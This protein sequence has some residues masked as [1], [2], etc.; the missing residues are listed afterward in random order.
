[1]GV[2]AEQL[3]VVM[4]A[5]VKNAIAG[6]R[7]YTNE[8]KTLPK[9]TQ[10]VNNSLNQVGKA[11]TK[12]KTD[13]TNFNRVLQDAPFGL[14]AIQNNLTQLVPNIGYLGLAVTA[15][16][17]ALTFAQ[18]GFGA[19]TRGLGSSAEKARD[20]A[21][22]LEEYVDG[23]DDVTRARVAGA[24]NAQE[25]LVSLQTLYKATQNSNIPLADRQY[26]KYFGN[27]KDEII[28][29]GGAEKQ[30]KEL[31][32]AIL[33]TSRA[34]AAQDILVDIQ[35]QLLAVEQKQTD[36]L[37]DQYKQFQLLN[38][39]RKQV[40]ESGEFDPKGIA[41]VNT[42]NVNLQTQLSKQQE[43][44]NSFVG[45]GV[46]LQ[47][48]RNDL[49]RRAENITK[50]ITTIVET[51]PEVL[52]D[53]TGNLPKEIEK[54]I[55]EFPGKYIKDIDI[56]LV[57]EIVI[58]QAALQRNLINTVAGQL[59]AVQGPPIIVDQ[60]EVDKALLLDRF[61][62]AFK[63]IGQ[64]LPKEVKIGESILAIDQV[65]NLKLL[66]DS[67]SNLLN[68]A[69]GPIDKFKGDLQA[70]FSGFS[71]NV[72]EGLGS[73]IGN[74]IASG[75]N[76]IEAAG[77][78]IASTIGD[79]ISQIGKALIEYGVVK[80]GLD[81][82]LAGGIAIPGVA[83]IAAG[84]AAVAIGA[85][86]KNSFK[87]KP[88]AEGGLVSGPVLG[89]VGEGR[90]TSRSNPEVIAPLDKLKKMIGDVGGGRQR[91]TGKL[92]VH[93]RELV[94]LVAVENQSQRRNR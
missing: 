62:K 83:A 49:L 91:L 8:A 88:F 48:Q 43:K 45:D 10:A 38:K 7:Q 19:W 34:R 32:N 35:K 87:V 57:P 74:A 79:L 65:N 72:F 58:D 31:A 50:E 53:P 5:D 6:M 25:E 63:D 52:L 26:P 2:V 21:K 85:L 75:Q 40:G 24:Q 78:S 37:T 44:Y 93:G 71:V 17:T 80:E 14:V 9:V 70:A 90:G 42:K 27:I 69:R 56:L 86:I 84:V 92:R 4:T 94:A 67:L 22:A 39:A 41:A 47:K 1:M 73:S 76:V 81:K 77:M 82:I 23:L 12:S 29:A 60:L 3:A 54:K 68:K 46:D 18:V 16:T 30:Y 15:V 33:Q 51:D 59:E 11:A 20:A 61:K 36:N 66:E 55:K 28:L 89:L 64:D 13:F